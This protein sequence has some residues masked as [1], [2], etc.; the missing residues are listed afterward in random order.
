[1]GGIQ[2]Q[3]WT[4]TKRRGPIAAEYSSPGP[5]CVTLPNLIGVSSVPDSKRGRAPAFSFGSRHG[6]KNDSPGP[7]PGQYNVTGL[8]AKG[9]DNPLAATLHSRPKEVRADLTPAPGDYNLEKSEGIMH[10]TSPKYTFGLKTQVEKPS[11]TPA[12]NVYNIPTV[13]GHTKEGNKKQAPAFTI[14]GRQKVPLDDRVLTPGPGSYNNAKADN[15][16]AKAPAYSIS[17]R[18]QMPSDSTMKPGPGAHSPE[19]ARLDNLPAHTF[20]IKHSPY[21]G[22]LKDN[23]W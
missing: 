1:M 13:L 20:G 2:Q 16:K 22:C 7:G 10:D 15:Y 12:P 11:Q 18:Y 3:Q 8:S 19:K 5:A 17:S 4:P 21:A 9:K 23:A 6:N 14:S